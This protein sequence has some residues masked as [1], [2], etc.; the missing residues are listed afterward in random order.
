MR[1][2]ARLRAAPAEESKEGRLKS[3]D[4]GE[5]ERENQEDGNDSKENLVAPYLPGVVVVFTFGVFAFACHKKYLPL[6]RSETLYFTV[7][8]EGRLH[9]GFQFF[10]ADRFGDVAIGAETDGLVYLHIGGFGGEH[11]DGQVLPFRAAAD[12]FQ[13]HQ[14]S[15]F[16]HA[17]IENHQIGTP[18]REQFLRRAAGV[19]EMP[20]L[21]IEQ[22]QHQANCFCHFF[23]IVH[24]PDVFHGWVSSATA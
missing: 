24:N 13:H 2:K 6:G 19:E 20:R 18:A 4:G 7:F 9:G 14:A 17:H 23:V 21:A 11:D 22:F 12:E 10:Q 3:G 16:G 8:S 15:D 5:G 1:Q